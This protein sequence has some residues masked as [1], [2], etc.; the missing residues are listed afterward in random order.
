MQYL[1]QSHG[2]HIFN[3]KSEKNLI[4]DRESR[5]ASTRISEAGPNSVH[6]NH[7][8]IQWVLD[9]HVFIGKLLFLVPYLYVKKS[10]HV[11]FLR[12]RCSSCKTPRQLQRRWLCI[13]SNGSYRPFP[14]QV[15]GKDPI[16]MVEVY[17]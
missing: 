3:T 9:N 11:L 5:D 12:L 2:C 16:Y 1:T 14:E 4:T 13:H 6:C 7:R 15:P 8:L 17:C 10:T